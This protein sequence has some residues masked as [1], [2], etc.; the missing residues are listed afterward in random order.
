MSHRAKPFLEAYSSIQK[1]IEILSD[2]DVATLDA[3]E[4][5]QIVELINA[6]AAELQGIVTSY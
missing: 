4:R 2:Q 6:Q 3:D 1:G 5:K